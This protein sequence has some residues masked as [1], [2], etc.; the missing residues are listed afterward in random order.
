[1]LL[2][3]VINELQS[4]M[5]RSAFLSYFF[6]QVTDIGTNSATAV[7]QGLLYIVVQQQPL[8]V[9]HIC[10]KDNHAGQNFFKDAN[11]WVALTEIFAN[12]LRDASLCTTYL[13]IDALDDCVTGLPKLLS[14]TTKQLSASSGVK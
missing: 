1:M 13:I 12:M 2:C 6:C 4:S 3:G 11:A 8:L 5:P 9:L 10:K 7:L 14:F